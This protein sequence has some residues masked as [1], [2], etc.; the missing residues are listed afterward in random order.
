MLNRDVV[1]LEFR[2]LC[3]KSFSMIFLACILKAE[4][5][6]F[7]IFALRQSI[8]W[9]CIIEPLENVHQWTSSL[10]Y[11]LENQKAF[12]LHVDLTMLI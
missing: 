9:I 12:A 10:Q 1:A 8:I 11:T 3:S 7:A 4:V 5:P 6:A 2:I